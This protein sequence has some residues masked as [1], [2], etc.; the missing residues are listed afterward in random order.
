MKRQ[1]TDSEKISLNH[2][3]DKGLVSGL[4]KELS[5]L[6]IKKQTTQLENG[7]KTCT[8]TTPKRIYRCQIHEKIFNIISH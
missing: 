5:K 7:Q 8:D 2:V 1:I 6:S 4:Y 3:S